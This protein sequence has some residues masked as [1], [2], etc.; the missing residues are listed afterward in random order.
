MPESDLNPM[1]QAR[2]GVALV[3][4]LV[5]AAAD[6]P[7]G[8]AAAKNL[9]QT[10][11][12]VTKLV[13][14]V[15]LPVAA[16]NFAF[17]RARDYFQNSFAADLEAKTAQIPPE[18]VVEP[19]ASVAGP[20][21]QGLAFAH[22]E[23][24]LK[25]LY[26]ELIAGAMDG[27]RASIAHPA[28]VEVLKQL[29]SEEANL[30]RVPIAARG[31]LPVAQIHA[32]AKGGGTSLLFNHVGYTKEDDGSLVDIQSL[33]AIVDNWIR[34]GLVEVSYV[35]SA[36]DMDGADPYHWLQK[37]PVYLEAVSRIHDQGQGLK[38]VHGSMRPT[39]FGQQFA[40]AV[41]ILV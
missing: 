13:N 19:K 4:D 34:L 35:I 8:K 11:V 25:D 31:L 36:V 22:E 27:R 16:V 21:L 17:D 28:F 26:L 5:K 15:L 30:L 9:G 14:N 6:S 40:R 32:I 24:Q 18:Q 29:T 7:E 23:P 10:A 33:P 3:S 41:G 37:H 1:E 38:V 39:S 12:T 2:T 20:A